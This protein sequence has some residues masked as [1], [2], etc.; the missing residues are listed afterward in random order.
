MLFRLTEVTKAYGAQEVLRAVT[1]QINPGEH[2][3]LV[4]R[5]GAGKTTILRLIAG[6]ETPD[7]GAV[8]R[9]RGFRYGALAQQVEFRG[10][11]TVIDSA[12]EV[13]EKLR[14]LETKMREMEHKM[15]ESSGAELD[16][17]MHEYSEAQQAYEQGGGFSYHSRAEAVLLGLGFT[18]EEFGKRAENLSGGE[19]NRLGLARLLLLE[20][21]ILLLDEPTNHLDVEAVEW[22]EEF[23]SDYKSA[24]LII[25]HD[26]FFLDH[27]VKRVLDLENGQVESYR[28]NYSEYL[29]ERE[30]RR[31]QRQRA[32]EQQQE[33]IARAEEFIRR[34]IAGQKT[35]QAKSRR[36]FL[37]RMERLENINNLETTNFKLKPAARTGDQVLVLDKLTIGFPSKAL[38]S[39]LSLLLRRGERLGI[40]GGN[41][42]GKTTLLRTI[43]GEHRPLDGELRWGA[44]VNIGY[45][46]QRLMVVDERNSV[47]EEL[48]GVA[49][50]LVTDGELRGFLG[51]FLFTGD[52]VFKPVSALSGGEKGRLALAKLIYSRVNVLALDEPTN[53]LDIAS[54]EALEDA[55]NEFNGTI[56]TVSH[57]RYFLDRVATQ[58]L[59]FGEKGVEYFDGG[60][61]EFYESHHRALAE[62]Q[63]REAEL[64]K[65]ERSRR[66]AAA[67]KPNAPRK[68]KQKQPSAAEIEA[69]IHS[70]EAELAELSMLISTEEIARDRARLFELSE[71]YQ[72]LD[73]KLAELYSSWEATLAD[74]ENISASGQFQN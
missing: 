34:N 16:R 42:V 68:P 47:I 69:L 3:G 24:Y 31:E 72:A 2:V 6:A 11:Q 74:E 48:R 14:A 5:N 44:G 59:C 30:E 38:A 60:Y 28:G 54:R 19:K 20:P 52:D 25:S 32:Y 50:S 40:I 39:D 51:R 45:Y 41:G 43:L 62:K 29:V 53:H 65:A 35:K 56:I 15:T 26:R 37:E 66:V 71:K 1:F 9:L 36:N 64:Q 17:V 55:L 4:G 7:D 21:D 63:A 67:A 22:L 23:L 73:H 70:V 27:T 58:I 18:K 57:D 12:L 46:D 33:M 49:I 8:E 10:E 61:S 13:F